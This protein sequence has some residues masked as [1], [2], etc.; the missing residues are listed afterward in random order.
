MRGWR[1]TS[2]GSDGGGKESSDGDMW[3]FTL[4][5]SV[6]RDLSEFKSYSKPTFRVIHCDFVCFWRDSAPPALKNE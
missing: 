6:G 3:A 5:T 1:G 2:M 4:V